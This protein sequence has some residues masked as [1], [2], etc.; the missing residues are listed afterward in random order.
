MEKSRGI[1]MIAFCSSSDTSCFLGPAARSSSV[2]DFVGPHTRL[3]GMRFASA[4]ATGTAPTET[5][6]QLCLVRAPQSGHPVDAPVTC[7]A[8]WTLSWATMLLP[9]QHT[10]PLAFLQAVSLWHPP[11]SP[12]VR[13]TTPLDTWTHFC[14]TSMRLDFVTLPNG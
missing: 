12:N 5:P 9:A 2:A 6:R 10:V 4:G 3:T 14:G 11:Q 7:V 8:S 13:P 1:R